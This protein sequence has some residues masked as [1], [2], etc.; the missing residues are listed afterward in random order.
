MILLG[1][2][3]LVALGIVPL[4]WGAA[5]IV[6]VAAI[7]LAETLFWVRRSRRGRPAV[8]AEAMVGEQAT[9]LRPCRPV[10]QVR[11]KGEIWRARCDDGADDG[12]RV[13]VRAVRG[14]DLIVE[15]AG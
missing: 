13:R 12:E 3:L 14:L 5:L 9:V 2:I 8:G 15:R 1:S 6:G 7:E 11:M 10:G 4:P